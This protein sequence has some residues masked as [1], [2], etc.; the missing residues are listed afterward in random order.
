MDFNACGF[1]NIHVEY[2]LFLFINL[3]LNA[4]A[5][6]THVRFKQ[7]GISFHVKMKA[8][9]FLYKNVKNVRRTSVKFLQVFGACM[10]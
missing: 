8:I 5:F 10:S 3:I 9:E 6:L 2:T 7:T 1:L 4:R